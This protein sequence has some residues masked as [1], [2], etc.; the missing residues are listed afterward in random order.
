MLKV[1]AENARFSRKWPLRSEVRL[2]ALVVTR[3]I[4]NNDHTA[5]NFIGKRLVNSSPKGQET[6]IIVYPA[7]VPP[8]GPPLGSE[9]NR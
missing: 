6:K 5:T 1:L 8:P 2:H 4:Y 7:R 9:A 3:H